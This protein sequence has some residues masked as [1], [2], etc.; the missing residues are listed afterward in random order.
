M[1]EYKDASFYTSYFNN[2]QKFNVIEEFKK[3]EDEEEKNLYVGTVEVV[4]TIHPLILRVEIPTTF[5][6]MKLTFRT[7]S[8]SGYPHLIHTG[9][10]KYGDWFC[11]NTP[12]AETAEEQL[13]QEISRLSEWINHQ[14]RPDLP[15]IIKDENV[16]QGLRF[17]NAYD[18]ENFD[19]MNEFRSKAILTFIGDFHIDP[20]S[21]KSKKGHLNCIKTPDNR[22]YAFPHDEFAKYKLPY[23]IVDEEP[24]TVETY[25]D[26]VLLKEQY[27]WGEDVC[28]HLLPGFGLKQLWTP[29]NNQL[30]RGVSYSLE[31]AL[32]KLQ[33]VKEELLKDDSY[34]PAYTEFDSQHKS[35][36]KPTK[37]L[38]HPKELIIKELNRLEEET[39]K[40]NGYDPLSSIYEPSK[41][42]DEMTLEEQEEEC[43]LQEKIDYELYV[44]PFEYHYFALGIQKQ[45]S[46]IWIIY[47]TYRNAG[48]YD[49][50]TFDLGLEEYSIRR[51]ISF[52][53]IGEM[54]QSVNRTMY[55][56]RGVFS[57]ILQNKKIALVG[58]GAIGSMVAE[59]LA[60]SGVPVIG[61]WDNDVV[62]PGNICRSSYLLSDLG[63]S[64]VD[65][66]AR[67]IRQID[68]FV[69][70]NEIKAN[71]YWHHFEHNFNI[72]TYVG[73]S[74][75]NNINYDDQEEC[76]NKLQEYDLIID[77]TGSNELLHFLSYAV[78]QT[79][80]VSLCIT[81][82][83]NE[84]V[85]VTSRDGNPF[86][87]RKAYLSRIEQDTKNFYLEGSGC[88]SPTFLATN[89]DIASL[90]NLAVRDLNA[91]IEKGCLPHS[92]I[93]SHDKRG[94][95]ADRLQTYK[96]E[97]YDIRMTI[98]SETMYDGEDME[99]S[100]NG[101]I[102]YLLGSYS[103]D[104]QLIMVTHFVDAL[105]AEH[106]LSDAFET[107]KGIIDYIGDF[108]YSDSETETYK[109]ESFNQI[110]HKASDNSINT[111]NPLLAIRHTDGTIS[112][113][114]FINN[115]LVRF[116]KED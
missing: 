58:L 24:K 94:V 33:P 12:F 100:P 107:S 47:Y 28:E 76:I 39:I 99:D 70:I 83:A 2:L 22:F 90:V 52:P 17:A 59:S 108:D 64:K 68:P 62:E 106:Y 93:W 5:P 23:I 54:S 61:L 88:Y 36:K 91:N 11:L 92:I 95:L 43:Y 103:K 41:P 34:L 116:I 29:K 9:K 4:G 110:A 96:L 114:L 3:S 74:F 65:A 71:G 50:V 87:L 102:G 8:I 104:G 60:R 112:F 105:N 51:L 45:D 63:D 113:F 80:I 15:A 19:E 57:D 30:L 38:K 98:S 27:G 13:N 101:H 77:C 16:I 89:S 73:G 10:I 84:L 14:M 81:N 97:G 1:L 40:N 66:L 75:Y 53:L 31:E 86:E 6:H 85:C 69:Q 25:R 115:K 32:A 72:K 37:V 35:E 109:I 49:V 21:F 111:C 26:F 78:P 67:K 48:Q 7:K 55:Y 79:D 56:G 18:W 44:S 46:I 20:N 42:Y 82:H